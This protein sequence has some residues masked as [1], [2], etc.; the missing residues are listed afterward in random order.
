MY[1]FYL[2]M[3][4]SRFLFKFYVENMIHVIIF[5]SDSLNKYQ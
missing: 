3:Y 2:K 4:R 5:A 1:G